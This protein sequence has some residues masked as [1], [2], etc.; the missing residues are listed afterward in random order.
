M[1]KIMDILKAL[2]QPKDFVDINTM[3][4]LQKVSEDIQQTMDSVESYKHKIESLEPPM[5][6]ERPWYKLDFGKASVEE[7]NKALESF[8]KFVQETF[9]LSATI[10]NCQNENDMNICRLLAL[11]ALAESNAYSK[12]EE[13]SAEIKDLSTEDEESA[14]QLK[15]LEDSF[16]Q[17]LN[18]SA[19]DSSKKEEQMARLIEYI[20]LFAESKTKKIRS[21]SLNLSEIKS[22]LDQ[23]C[24]VQDN[25]VTKTNGIIS[26]WQEEIA[27]NL[28]DTFEQLKESILRISSEKNSQ[29]DKQFAQLNTKCVQIIEDHRCKL[30]QD[31]NSQKERVDAS[32]KIAEQ[33]VAEY[34][35]IIDKQENALSIMSQSIERQNKIIGEIKSKA[36]STIIVAVVSAL[37]AVCCL[38]Y[39]ILV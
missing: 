25:W 29:I 3:H 13:V 10:Q 6:N 34:K 14:K 19:I 4:S 27:K 31:I 5:V 2:N 37:T 1:T 39:M 11:L 16:L 22:K 36:S 30:E 32:L 18:D 15:E 8:S 26:S 35:N 28:N 38:T 7:V 23:Y 12:L 21:I 9:K 20:T 33:K 24:S 17:S